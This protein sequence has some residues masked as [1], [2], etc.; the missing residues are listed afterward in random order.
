VHA[1]VERVLAALRAATPGGAVGASVKSLV[2]TAVGAPIPVL[3]SASTGFA[4]GDVA[5]RP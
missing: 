5:A 2:L 3:A 1:N 4:V